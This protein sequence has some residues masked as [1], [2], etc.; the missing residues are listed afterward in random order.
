[1]FFSAFFNKNSKVYNDKFVSKN[2]TTINFTYN[3]GKCYV[4]N[5][6]NY[7]KSLL[8]EKIYYCE[9]CKIKVLIK[10]KI[11]LITYNNM[12]EMYLNSKK[13]E[14]KDFI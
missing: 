1:M 3:E 7:L 13:K 6:K 12:I 10:E 9:K 5:S 2:V 14:L 4:C 8:D 11:D